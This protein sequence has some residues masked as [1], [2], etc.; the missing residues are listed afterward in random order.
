MLEECEPSPSMFSSPEGI[1]RVSDSA[2][3]L[4]FPGPASAGPSDDRGNAV[5]P[6]E[7]PNKRRTTGTSAEEDVEKP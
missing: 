6:E 4:D 7:D 3:C 5:V 1:C 2:S